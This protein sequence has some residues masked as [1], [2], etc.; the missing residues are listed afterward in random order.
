MANHLTNRREIGYMRE[1]KL[2]GTQQNSHDLFHLHVKVEGPC[3]GRGSYFFIDMVT[4]DNTF[5]RI[6][7]ASSSDRPTIIWIRKI[8]R[9][10][11]KLFNKH[12]LIN[13][14]RCIHIMNI[15]YC[16]CKTRSACGYYLVST[17]YWHFANVMR[18]VYVWVHQNRILLAITYHTT[19]YQSEPVRWE[20]P[21]YQ[22]CVELPNATRG[23]ATSHSIHIDGIVRSITKSNASG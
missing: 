18:F 2:K 4:L 22:G 20:A 3:N 11:I 10:Y 17:V 23:H 16:Y 9:V 15:F 5:R 19:Y 6:Y 1:T 12:L 21:Y 7:T 8:A 13:A 14:N